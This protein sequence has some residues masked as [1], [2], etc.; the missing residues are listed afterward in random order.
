VPD[1]ESD[2]ETYL[3]KQ[4]EARGGRC[5]KLVDLGRRGF[6]DRTVLW[7][8]EHAARMMQFIETKTTGGIVK[9]WQER[10]HVDLK[11]MG[12][13]VLTL[14]TKEQVDDYIQFWAPLRWK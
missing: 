8:V 3:V 14:W 13:N 6:P 2:V 9:S 10:Y 1:I 5:L 4:V 11:S 12:Y 7:P